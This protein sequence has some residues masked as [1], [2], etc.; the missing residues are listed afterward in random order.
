MKIE[1]MLI[2]CVGKTVICAESNVSLWG[3]Y[4]PR[5]PKDISRMI[6]RKKSKSK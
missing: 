5:K 2:N 4:Q 6:N 1:K 3:M